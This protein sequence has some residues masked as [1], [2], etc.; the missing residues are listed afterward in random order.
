MDHKKLVVGSQAHWIDSSLHQGFYG[1]HVGDKGNV[2]RRKK[3]PLHEWSTSMGTK[4]VVT[5]ECLYPCDNDHHNKQ[6]VWI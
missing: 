1:D 5:L 6:I 4:W 3:I 2:G